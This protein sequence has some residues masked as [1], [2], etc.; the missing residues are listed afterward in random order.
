M[1][2]ILDEFEFFIVSSSNLQVTGTTIKSQTNLNSGHIHPLTSVLPALENWKNVVDMI[3][4][5]VLIGSS[6]NF[7][8][9]RTGIKSWT[10]SISGQSRLFA[11]ELHALEH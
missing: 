9:T 8:T 10:S 11:S 5:S 6:A 1:H 3:A 2:K 4:P 7:Q